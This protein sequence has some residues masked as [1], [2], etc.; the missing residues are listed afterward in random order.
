MQKTT[1]MTDC[2]PRRTLRP[3]HSLAGREKTE[4]EGSEEEWGEEGGSQ[5]V[6][7]ARVKSGR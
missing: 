3:E 2:Q 7:I 6:G 1:Q 5:V 4:E